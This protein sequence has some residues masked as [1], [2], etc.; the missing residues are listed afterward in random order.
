MFIRFTFSQAKASFLSCK[1]DKDHLERRS[2]ELQ[3]IVQADQDDRKDWKNKTPAEIEKVVSR[4][5][6]RRMRVG[7]IFGKG[8]FSKAADYAA[9]ALVFQHGNS[10]D[11][12]F[13]TYIWSKRGVDLGDSNQKRMMALGIDG[14]LVNVGKKQ[15][16]A[17]QATKPDL[18]ACWCLHQVES[19][20]PDKECTQGLK[21]SPKGT[22]SGLW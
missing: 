4:D 17:T 2:Q 7:E 13:Q 3:S 21:A 18:E 15:L 8:C 6:I 16:F 5:E 19:N 20:F 1:E 9:A 14:Y 22:V 12:F 11:H 10:A